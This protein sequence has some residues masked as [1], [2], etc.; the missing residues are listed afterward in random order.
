MPRHRL[1]RS[2]DTFELRL[3]A[4]NPGHGPLLASLQSGGYRLRGDRVLELPRRSKPKMSLPLMAAA[5][6]AVGLCGVVLALTTQP[7]VS[8]KVP[9]ERPCNSDF[10]PTGRVLQESRLGG[11]I[12][13]Q[14]ETRCGRY[15]VT[16]DGS[17]QA[18]VAVKRL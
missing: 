7:E 17:N 14:L 12:V 16:L 18:I 4:T 1:E 10:T 11:V 5:I 15:Q 13:Q 2:V 8:K 6:S 3:D 9:R